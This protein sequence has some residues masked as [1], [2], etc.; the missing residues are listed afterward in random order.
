MDRFTVS[1]FGHREILDLGRLEKQAFSLVREI[2]RKK[3]YTTFLIGRNGEFDTYTASI[4]KRAQKAMGEENSEC[5]CVLPYPKKDM[6]YYENYYDGIIIPECTEGFHPKSAILRRNRWMVEEA[7][8]LIFYVERKE[9]GAYT[10]FQYA[11]SLNKKIINLAE[12]PQEDEE[13][14]W[15]VPLWRDL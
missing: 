11:K 3:A 8:L 4:I 2:I 15:G 1:L 7:D 9:G 6:E 13:L 5:I 14:T 12:K 10:A